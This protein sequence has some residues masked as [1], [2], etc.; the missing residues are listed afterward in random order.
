MPQRNWL[1][2]YSNRSART[3]STRQARRAGIQQA[4]SAT[5]NSKPATLEIVSGSFAEIP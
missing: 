4:P 2:R 3:G 5:S 1:T